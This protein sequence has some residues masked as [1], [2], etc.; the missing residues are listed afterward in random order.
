[1]KKKNTIATISLVILT[2]VA[3]FYVLYVGAFIAIPLVIALFLSFA[4]LSLS[5]FFSSKG[6]RSEIA[7]ILS[8]LTFCGFFWV[9]TLIINS[10]VQEIINEAPVY[11]EKLTN[12]VTDFAGYLNVDRSVILSEIT[13]KMD[14]PQMISSIAGA[15]TSIVK[16]T[17]TIVF[18]T[19][20]ILL[21]SRFMGRKISL[22]TE[23]SQIFDIINLIRKDMKTYFVIKS[24]ISLSTGICSYV[25]LLAFGIDFALF[26]AFLI[27]LLN[28][29]P[30]IGSIIAVVFPVTFSL[31][32]FES[33]SLTLGLLA[34]LTSVQVLFGNVIEPRLMGNKL[35]LSPLVI[36]LSLLF[37][38]KIWG[39]VG[40]L[41]CVPIMVMI[42]IVLAHIPATRPIAILLSEQGNI[43]F[44]NPKKPV[45]K[46]RF[47]L[48]R[49]Q[50]QI[51]KK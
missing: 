39:V 30:T 14:I 8:L 50:K 47:M 7:F 40:M 17:G 2:L 20:F 6:I 35:N 28:Y 25:I 32:Q 11:Q 15:V 26:W 45:G 10:N 1:M 12:M 48:K 46:G 21:E 41:L 31:I 49:M 27:F 51:F 37:W 5:H 29:V 4:I 23:N 36:L 16:S 38:G 22:M 3:V 42:N 19:I 44:W 13:N 9:I 18:F 33:I 43:K 24:L 34:I